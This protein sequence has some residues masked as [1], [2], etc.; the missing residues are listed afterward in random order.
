MKKD[1]LIQV[2]ISAEDKAK[3]KELCSRYGMTVSS[4][5]SLILTQSVKNGQLPYISNTANQ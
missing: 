1:D 4:A 2:R 3:A 5:V